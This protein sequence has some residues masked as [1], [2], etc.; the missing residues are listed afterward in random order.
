MVDSLTLEESFH[1]KPIINLI[2]SSKKMETLNNLTKSQLTRYMPEARI[3]G[4][5]LK[6][7]VQAIFEMNEAI[8]EYICFEEK[9]NVLAAVVVAYVRFGIGFNEIW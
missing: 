7:E 5:V 8:K 4:T 6:L 2:P 3:E 9:P 1:S